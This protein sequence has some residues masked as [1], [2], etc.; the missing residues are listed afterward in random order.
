MIGIKKGVE[1][2]GL[3][4][5]FGSGGVS[6]PRR[7][8]TSSRG[9]SDNV[10]DVVRT[11]PTGQKQREEPTPTPATQIRIENVSSTRRQIGAPSPSG[12]DE[13]DNLIMTDSDID[14]ESATESD[15]NASVVV[16]RSRSVQKRANGTK[17]AS[18]E[19]APEVSIPKKP[20]PVLNHVGETKTVGSRAFRFKPELDLVDDVPPR[21]MKLRSLPK[22]TYNV[23]PDLD[24]EDDDSES[25][26]SERAHK[27]PRHDDESPD[28]DAASGMY[29]PVATR[30]LAFTDTARQQQS[31]SSLL[32]SS[33]HPAIRGQ[34]CFRAKGFTHADVMDDR[35]HQSI[36]SSS[37]ADRANGPGVVVETL[38]STETLKA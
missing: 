9:N 15:T 33:P 34:L 8:P 36:R 10:K 4:E 28:E 1:E 18:S 6:A 32:S 31:Q 7:K 19:P 24:F 37:H 38:M 17:Y 27:K 25:V 22:R 26:M 23:S 20:C 16:V 11:K 29:L 14:G 35:L 2:L 30:R 21:V 12:E 5:F 13:E 3:A